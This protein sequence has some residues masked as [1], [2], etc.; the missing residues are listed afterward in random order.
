MSISPFDRMPHRHGGA[1]T[2]DFRAATLD[3]AEAVAGVY[4]R[5]RREL[6]AWAP[7]VHSD[8]AIRGWIRQHLIPSGHTTVAVADGQVIGF[9]AVSKGMMRR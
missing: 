2:A 5:S 3:D 4:L 8:E 6:V 1:A 9:L 7:L